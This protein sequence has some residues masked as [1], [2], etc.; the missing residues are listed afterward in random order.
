VRAGRD[1]LPDGAVARLG[2]T[3]FR[4][5]ERVAALAYSPDGKLLATAGGRLVRLWEARTGREVA[6]L[7]GPTQDL[8]AVAFSPDGQSIGAGGISK[9]GP[10]R[11]S[12]PTANSWRSA[13]GSTRCGCTTS[14]RGRW[15]ARGRS[16]S[17][18]CTA[19]PGRRTASGWRQAAPATPCWSGTWSRGGRCT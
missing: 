15:S 9:A 1:R 17:K 11:P 13:T 2:A 19:S 8:F 4:H 7:S 16:T 18:E 3:H 10:R 12:L 14:P 6:C 5:G